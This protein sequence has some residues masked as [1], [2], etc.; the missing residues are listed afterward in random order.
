MTT[1]NTQCASARA[2][3][4][5]DPVLFAEHNGPRYRTPI[6]LQVTPDPELRFLVIGAC[7]AEALPLIGPMI[8]PGFKG[9]FILMNQFDQAVDLSSA[10][11]A[12]YDFQ[13][14]HL[15]LRS[16]LGS[17]F[18]QLPDDAGSACALFNQRAEVEWRTK[19]GDVRVGIV[20]TAAEP[21]RAI[22]AS[23]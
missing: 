23:L 2:P 13:I 4:S 14:V 19:A 12:Q 8:N 21:A 1:Q 11:A 10:A 22:S 15:P 3:A 9:D 6:D 17:A 7:L 5:V 20:R 16:I 18:F